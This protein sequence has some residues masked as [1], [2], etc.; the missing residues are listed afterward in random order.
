MNDNR[1]NIEE[2]SL[3]DFSEELK[4]KKLRLSNV[5]IDFTSISSL[6]GEKKLL[7]MAFKDTLK[8]FR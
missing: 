1:L 8:G 7:E 3:T 6:K 5:E 2:V 4:K